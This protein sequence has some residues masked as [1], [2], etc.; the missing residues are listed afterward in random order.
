M[1]NGLVEK[2]ISD[3][4][5]REIRRHLVAKSEILK[6]KDIELIREYEK[7]L[8]YYKEG[9]KPKKAVIQTLEN[10]I[11]SILRKKRKTS[12]P[13]TVYAIG[14][15][16]H[17]ELSI[18][19]PLPKEVYRTDK[20]VA[21]ELYRHFVD[22]LSNY[23]KTQNDVYIP[24]K[25]RDGRDHFLQINTK[26]FN[27]SKLL[28]AITKLETPPDDLINSGIQIKVVVYKSS[29]GKPSEEYAGEVKY[30]PERIEITLPAGRKGTPSWK[31]YGIIVLPRKYRSFFPGY[32][33][34]FTFETD[35]MTLNKA[36]VSSAPQG[37]KTG[38]PKAGTFI[39]GV[40]RWYKQIDPSPGDTL[41]ITPAEPGKTYKLELRKN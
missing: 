7:F 13:L 6:S 14:G 10:D 19:L 12:K 9:P 4:N 21:A 17:E 8:K 33:T 2:L 16:R 35:I 40:K 20:D 36:K 25:S 39:T 23:G 24:T 18:V 27:Q 3:L 31:K 37:T 30:I 11:G 41:I 15:V 1:Q 34:E 26:E 29:E 28:E 38:D 32:N 22:A 5:F